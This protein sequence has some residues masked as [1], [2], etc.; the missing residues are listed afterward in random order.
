MSSSK[1]K[2]QDLFPTA[3]AICSPDGKL[4]HLDGIHGVFEV[5]ANN[6]GQLWDES[7]K[8][9][10]KCPE[11]QERYLLKAEFFEQFTKAPR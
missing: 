9:I 2:V 6:E 10:K 11:S 5:Q 8:H 7:L 4:W 1:L 3:E